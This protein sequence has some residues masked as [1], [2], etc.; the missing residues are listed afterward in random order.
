[1]PRGLCLLWILGLTA[2]CGGSHGGAATAA[3]KTGVVNQQGAQ[4]VLAD[5][6]GL[7]MALKAS[8]GATLSGKVSAIATAGAQRIV[9]P[10]HGLSPQAG[11]PVTISGTSG[12]ATCDATGCT[13][14][15]FMVGGFTYNGSIEAT[16]QATG[17]S[18]V[19]DMTYKG[20]VT[21]AGSGGET[22]DWMISGTLVISP[23]SINGSLQSTGSGHI[24]SDGQT[25]DYTYDDLVQ[26][27]DVTIDASG[28]ATGG[29]IYARWSA[30]FTGSAQGSQ[31]W[32]GTVSFGK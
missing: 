1:M 15:D 17:T 25:L 18:V 4:A 12:T 11:M 7:V 19:A 28:T 6:T 22:L 26:Y 2:G 32:E 9:H 16:Q 31:S 14:A 29:S 10:G 13:Y 27:N 21:T 5:T 23:T 30:T 3:T 20:S 24:A 8:D